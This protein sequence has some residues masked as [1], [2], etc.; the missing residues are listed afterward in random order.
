MKEIKTCAIIG[1]THNEL[2]LGFDEKTPEAAHL[3]KLVVETVLGVIDA[4]CDTIV[5]SLSF[6]VELWAAEACSL[7]KQSGCPVK[8]VCIPVSET[9]TN[10]WPEP[11]RDRFFSFTGLSDEFLEQPLVDFDDPARKIERDEK[12]SDDY[13]VSNSDVV[14]VVGEE[15][16]ARDFDIMSRAKDRVVRVK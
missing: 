12:F 11:I 15:L 4:G 8:L 5:T 3:K 9:M 16:G 6:G 1:S 13:I 14:V 2:A 7:L 10:D